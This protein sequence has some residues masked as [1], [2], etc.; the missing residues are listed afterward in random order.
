MN[1]PNGNPEYHPSPEPKKELFIND[2][3]DFSQD[4]QYLQ[5][6]KEALINLAADYPLPEPCLSI[7][8]NGTVFG[9]GAMGEFSLVIGK[10]KSRKTFFAT[11]MVAETLNKLPKGK[12]HVLFFDTEQS[13]HRVYQV[14]HRIL[15]L[16][17]TDA[18]TRLHL[19]QLRKLSPR[20][21]LKFID[22]ELANKSN[23]NVGL[24]VIDGIRDLVTSINDEFQSTEISSR[25]MK[26]SEKYGFHIMVVLHQNKGDNNAR[27]HLGSEL[28]NKAES[29]I[30]VAID[31]QDRNLSVINC[32]FSR[33]VP[34][35]Q[36]LMGIDQN[37]LPYHAVDDREPVVK[38]SKLPSPD[39]V[40]PEMHKKITLSVFN[41]GSYGYGET[42]KRAKEELEKHGFKMG[43]NKTKEFIQYWQDKEY[44]QKNDKVYSLR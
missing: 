5:M 43:D 23:D 18:I 32:E 44:I 42:V 15:A 27:G 29:V 28:V 25:I 21:R 16:S 31:E 4:P 39:E 14:G 19:F 10:A 12:D 20:E 24:V 38:K 41:E 13:V 9:L 33:D 34:F 6:R 35:E 17:Q 7:E 37:G 8:Q 30:S 40:T 1:M 26:W 3:D 22:Q 11:M 36:F 2:M